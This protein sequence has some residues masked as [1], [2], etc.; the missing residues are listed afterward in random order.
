[1]ADG[2]VGDFAQVHYNAKMSNT[3]RILMNCAVGTFL[4]ACMLYINYSRRIDRSVIDNNAIANGSYDL[5]V[6]GKF[7]EAIAQAE[8]AIRRMPNDALGYYVRGLA[9]LK[10]LGELSRLDDLSELAISKQDLL[11]AKQLTEKDV[12]RNFC[13]EFLQKIEE[14]EKQAKR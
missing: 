7:A 14:F 3:K 2:F 10:L 6:G 9:R 1:M 12:V 5:M 8:E 4:L 11:K 13:I